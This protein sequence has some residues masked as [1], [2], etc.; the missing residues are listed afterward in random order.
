MAVF[1][2]LNGASPELGTGPSHTRL[3]SSLCEETEGAGEK[4]LRLR[5]AVTCQGPTVS[6]RLRGPRWFSLPQNHCAKERSEPRGWIPA[7]A[8]NSVGED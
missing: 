2:S 6:G 5:E 4:K 1:T 8:W 3:S 7:H